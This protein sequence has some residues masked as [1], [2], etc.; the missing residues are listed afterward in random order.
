[1]RKKALVTLFVS[2]VLSIL[3]LRVNA[4]CINID[5][6]ILDRPDTWVESS[7]QTEEDGSIH[8]EYKCDNGSVNIYTTTYD[9]D[10]ADF[11]YL[12]MDAGLTSIR[13]MDGYSEVENSTINLDGKT[14]HITTFTYN[15]NAG[16]LV[17][18]D[19]G[20]S[21]VDLMY[22]FTMSK[23]NQCDEFANM[24]DNITFEEE[25]KTTDSGIKN[26]RYS[27]GVYK[28]GNDIPAGE[29]VVFANGGKGYFCVSSDSNQ[30]DI[31]FNENFEY[32]SII[33]IKDGE[34]LHLTRSYAIPIE[35]NPDVNV[36]A[37]GMFKVGDHI[38]AGEYKLEATGEHGYYCIYPD[39]R[40]DDIVANDNFEG[41]NYVT[42]SEGQYLLLNRCKFAE[43]PAKPVKSYSDTDTVMKVQQA[44]NSAG[45]DCG[46]P[47]GIAGNGTKTQIEKY[48]T[49][50]NLNVTGT[51]TDELLGTLKIE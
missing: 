9:E 8:L 37:S 44:L 31:L 16:M 33:T 26:A 15:E 34:Y 29:Y 20:K 39:S 38:P 10:I 25:N 23:D 13:K 51:I 36:N 42:V 14:G 24:I 43:P 40:Q 45:Y 3:P 12:L 7:N 50:N 28:V 27:A 4:E 49:D 35:E 2:T 48:Q 18:A 17:S 1:M 41:Q 5:G 46:T 21:I 22:V 47:D 11:S 6:M 19:T 32:N 30:D